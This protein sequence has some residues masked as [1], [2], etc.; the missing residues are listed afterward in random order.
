LSNASQPSGGGTTGFTVY[1]PGTQQF[2]VLQFG[3]N[4]EASE[5]NNIV[6]ISAP[7]VATSQSV[8]DSLLSYVNGISPFSVG[9]ELVL[10]TKTGSTLGLNQTLGNQI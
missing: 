5:S 8:S 1:N 6:T 3:T 10:L 7:D 2:K 4:I 9:D